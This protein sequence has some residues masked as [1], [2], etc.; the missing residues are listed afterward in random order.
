M[1]KKVLA[2]IILGA[3]AAA[4]SAETVIAEWDFSKEDVLSSGKMPFLLRRGKGETDGGAKIVDGFLIS[5]REKGQDK[6]TGIIS[7][8][9][10]QDYSP[11]GA[12]K[13]TADFK[14]EEDLHRQNI[15]A[16]LFDNKYVTMPKE[17]QKN[18]HNGFQVSFRVYPGDKYAPRAAFGFGE[19]SKEVT[20]KAVVLEKGKMHHLEVYFNAKGKV[21]FSLNGKEVGTATVPEG[22]IAPSKRTTVIGDRYGSSYSAFGGAISKVALI[23]VEEAEA[24][25]AAEEK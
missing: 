9:P 8:K 22:S 3:M 13:F 25:A 17:T 2:T 12:F 1:F 15:V 16:T 21:T 5:T 19:V 20:G 14:F 24:P 23:K 6:P 18:M 11:S 7:V 4:F 10:C